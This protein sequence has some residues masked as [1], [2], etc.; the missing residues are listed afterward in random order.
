MIE[1]VWFGFC[2]VW[3][4]QHTVRAQGRCARTIPPSPITRVDT[5]GG[6]DLLPVASGRGA[7]FIDTQRR[8]K[9][10]N[11]PPSAGERLSH[12]ARR[13]PVHSIRP[14]STNA[15]PTM[16]TIPAEGCSLSTAPVTGMSGATSVGV[17]A[18]GG[19]HELNVRSTM[20]T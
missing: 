6:D 7:Q 4:E 2:P 20:A 3:C 8:R 17:G 16:A 9:P 5:P 10:H 19:R 15:K 1:P 11:G 12:R 14:K 18:G 13:L